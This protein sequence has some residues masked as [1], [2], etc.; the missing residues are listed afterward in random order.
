[1]NEV[2]DQRFTISD[3]FRLGLGLALAQIVLA[4][5]VGLAVLALVFGAAILGVV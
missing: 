4:A 2:K 5:V 1:M 3:G